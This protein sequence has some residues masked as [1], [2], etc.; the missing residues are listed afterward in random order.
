[1][2]KLFSSLAALL[3]LLC[4]LPLSVFADV[5]S[6]NI[7]GSAKPA[8]SAP[9]TYGSYGSD[10]SVS[11]VIGDQ[12]VIWLYEHSY[13]SNGGT[14]FGLDNSDGRFPE[15]SRL[16]IRKEWSSNQ[17]VGADPT[18]GPLLTGTNRHISGW[19]AD[20]V[21]DDGREIDLSGKEPTIYIQLGDDWDT[22]DIEARF[23]D[24]S[25]NEVVP[26]GICNLRSPD[27]VGTFAVL[28]LTNG[29]RLAEPEA[30]PSGEDSDTNGFVGSVIS[31]GSSLA[32]VIALIEFGVIIGMVATLL[33]KRK[34]K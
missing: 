22:D 32:A 27:G 5:T 20:I 3:L 23:I 15:G 8:G 34:A 11:T 29:F 26:I 7:V 10:G 13:D 31:D 24:E 28:E 33:L 30:S 1:M 9:T 16:V 12:D 25:G 6:A 4:T 17:D 21:D 2:K 18:S 19:S 14:W